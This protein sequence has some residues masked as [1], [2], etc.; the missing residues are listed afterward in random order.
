MAIA[1]FSNFWTGCLWKKCTS[2]VLV[3]KKDGINLQILCGIQ[4]SVGLPRRSLVTFFGLGKKV[5]RR[6][7]LR[8]AALGERVKILKMLIKDRALDWGL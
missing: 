1:V 3:E 2:T 8:A 6:R 5:T 7:P 4:Q